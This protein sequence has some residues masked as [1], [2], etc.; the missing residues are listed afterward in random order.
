MNAK[1]SDCSCVLLHPPG[2]PK[3]INFPALLRK[4]Q[5]ES[6]VFEEIE[7]PKDWQHIGLDEWFFRCTLCNRKWRFADPD[8]PFRGAWGEID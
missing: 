4:L 2:R 3:D 5:K 6:S 8:G 1:L 7:R